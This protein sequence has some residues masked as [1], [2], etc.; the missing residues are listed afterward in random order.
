M[1]KQKEPPSVLMLSVPEDW[2][3][4]HDD[5]AVKVSSR[6]CGLLEQ[7]LIEQDHSIPEWVQ[8]GCNEDS[9]VYYQSMKNEELYVY[10]IAYFPNG[11]EQ[12]RPQMYI[13]YGFK[14]SFL[15]ALLGR[16]KQLDSDH[17]LHAVMSK[18]GETFLASRVLTHAQFNEELYK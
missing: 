14:N 12:S 2:F 13:S 15:K 8:G 3:E 18:F 6:I 11:D 1:S 4:D 5:Y 16:K 9:Y 10:T 7:H 17:S